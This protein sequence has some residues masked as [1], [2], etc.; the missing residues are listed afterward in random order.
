[1]RM[2]E[3][4]CSSRCRGR[5]NAGHA[6][7]DGG[8]F[9]GPGAAEQRVCG[10]HQIAPLGHSAAAG[11]G[12]LTEINVRSGDHVKAGQAMMAID[13]LH[14]QASVDSQRATER[15]KKAV[16]DYNDD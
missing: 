13:P 3:K 16:F 9:A 6:G 12:R 10:D 7:A 11:D 8:C 5:G 4:G 15:Q 14:Q 2:P 1:M